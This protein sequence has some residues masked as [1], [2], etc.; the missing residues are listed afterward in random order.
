MDAEKS[1]I[2]L[3]TDS[4]KC[5][6]CKVGD[7]VLVKK[8][9][10]TNDTFI[11]YTRDGT[12]LACH[13]EYRCTN[14]TLPCRAGHFYGYVSLGEKGNSEKPRCYEKFALKKEY[15]ITSNQTA[16]SINYLWDCLLQILFS[17]AS[18][19]SLAK[20]YNNFHFTNL[21]MDVMKTPDS[22]HDI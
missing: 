19:D 16:F 13:Q 7:E 9:A 1:S 10:T 5:K 11:V 2:I 4:R 6:V 15:L 14:R 20:V 22:R 21:P 8:D 12:Q 3:K 17:N 18:F